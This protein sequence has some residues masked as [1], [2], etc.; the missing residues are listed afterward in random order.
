M[1]TLSSGGGGKWKLVAGAAALLAAG[2]ILLAVLLDTFGSSGGQGPSTHFACESCGHE[3]DAAMK[4]TPACPQCGAAPVLASRYRCPKCRHEFVGI[5]RQ[6]IGVG[7]FRYRL[8]GEKEWR[9]QRPT[10]LT[11][12]QCRYR[13]PEIESLHGIPAVGGAGKPAGTEH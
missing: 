1:V 9:N 8:P 5:E 4:A 7:R 12:P 13:S 10:L 2:G 11:C 6:K 3:W